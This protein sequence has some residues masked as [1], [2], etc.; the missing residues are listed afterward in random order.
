MLVTA[1]FKGFI[2]F[3]QQATL[4]LKVQLARQAIL[5]HKVLPAQQ[6]T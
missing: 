1:L 4:V 2:E 5:V 6:E 3:A